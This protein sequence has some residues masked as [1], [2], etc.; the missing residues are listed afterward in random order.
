MAA[1][2]EQPQT[3]SNHDDPTDPLK[4]WDLEKEKLLIQW[5]DRSACYGW[6]HEKSHHKYNQINIW[7]TIPVIVL[8][9]LGGMANFGLDRFSEDQR[10]WITITI[11]TISVIAGLITTISHFL[12]I[13]EINEA[14]KKASLDWTKF[15]RDIQLIV[16]KKPYQRLPAGSQMDIYKA[17]YDRY[18]ENAPPIQDDIIERF[19]KIFTDP[20]LIKPEICGQLKS[21]NSLNTLNFYTRVAREDNGVSNDVA[22]R[23][24][25][26]E[27][28]VVDH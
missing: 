23:I 6:L 16:S 3:S 28:S 19:N 12:K 26:V 7:F 1:I 17:L 25:M 15:N 20:D 8:S 27:V 14:H 21:T 5:A 18:M 22:S 13:G 11:G 4:G 2:M 24:D 9:S 10:Q